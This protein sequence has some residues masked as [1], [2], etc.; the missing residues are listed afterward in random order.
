M[1]LVESPRPATHG[2]H[3]CVCRH[4]PSQPLGIG[5]GNHRPR[6][7]ELATVAP[8]WVLQQV[9][10][11]WFERYGARFEAYRLP[12]EKEERVQ[13]QAQIGADG[14]HLLTAVYKCA[15][16]PWLRE[17]PAVDMM[18]Q[19]WVEQYKEAKTL[20]LKRQRAE[21]IEPG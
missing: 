3:A 1:R 16:L 15:S 21:V 19:I 10:P 6:A 18:R 11:D 5:W 20:A 14:S 17:L 8:E 13:L 12:K 7:E 2:F 9:S 4:P